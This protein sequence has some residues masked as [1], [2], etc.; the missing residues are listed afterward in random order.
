MTA[1]A[2]ESSP[3]YFPGYAMPGGT[4][5]APPMRRTSR[6]R[7]VLTWCLAI[8]VIIW[9]LTHATRWEFIVLGAVLVSGSILY[10]IGN[11]VRTSQPA[12]HKI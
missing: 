9:M 4:Y 8:A 2:P 10:L 7:L 3:T 1:P 11:F 5:A 6:T 12:S